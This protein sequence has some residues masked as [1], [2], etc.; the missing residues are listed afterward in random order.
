MPFDANCLAGLVELDR[1]VHRAV[2]GE[3]QGWH[4]QFNS[5]LGQFPATAETVE[6]RVLTV[7]VEVHELGHRL[8]LYHRGWEIGRLGGW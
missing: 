5:A 4:T 2:V 1:A 6:E 3:S 8:R 7:D